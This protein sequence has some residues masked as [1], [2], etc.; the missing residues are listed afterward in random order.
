MALISLLVVQDHKQI[1][2]SNYFPAES[3]YDAIEEE[4]ELT[5]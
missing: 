3:L 1:C 5:Q 2:L 4:T